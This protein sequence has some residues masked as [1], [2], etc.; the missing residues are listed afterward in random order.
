M[1]TI[2]FS[3]SL[4]KDTLWVNV[5]GITFLIA[6]ALIG[7]N[8]FIMTFDYSTTIIVTAYISAQL[9]IVWGLLFHRH[10]E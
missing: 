1:A 2:A 9:M 3:T 5:G 8:R 10:G 7:V 6:D 4:V